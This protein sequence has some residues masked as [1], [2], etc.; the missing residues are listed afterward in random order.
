MSRRRAISRADALA[1][2]RARCIDGPRWDG[3]RPTVFAN[4]SRNWRPVAAGANLARVAIDR[5]LKAVIRVAETQ[6]RDIQLGQSASIDTRNGVVEGRVARIDPSVRD[7][8]VTVDITLTGT[9]P[10]GARADLSIDGTIQLERLEKVVFVGRPAFGD[11]EKKVSCACSSSFL[12]L[13][14]CTRLAPPCTWAAAP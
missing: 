2:R 4:G 10:R 11:K 9:L 12:M 3:R 7:G 6:V 8:T 14:V 1:S 5:E 13:T